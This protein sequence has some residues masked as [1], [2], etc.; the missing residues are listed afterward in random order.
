MVCEGWSGWRVDTRGLVRNDAIFV[1][2]IDASRLRRRLVLCRLHLCV[3]AQR[4]EHGYEV[5]P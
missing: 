4:E 1:A 2:A 3:E 5:L